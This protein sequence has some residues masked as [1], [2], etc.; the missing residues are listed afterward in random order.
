MRTLG[1]R[2]EGPGEYQDG[3]YLGSVYDVD[4]LHE[5]LVQRGAAVLR[6]PE[7]FPYGMREIEIADPDGHRLTF[8]RSVE[9]S[10]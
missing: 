10:V 9:P 3:S 7:T 8:A 6:A 2:G 4:A 5:S 1:G